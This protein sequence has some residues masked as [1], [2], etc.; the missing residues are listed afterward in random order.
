MCIPRV[1][2]NLPRSWSLGFGLGLAEHAGL[3]S[4]YWRFQTAFQYRSWKNTNWANKN[5]YET[6]ERFTLCGCIP[7]R[8]S[9]LAALHVSVWSIAA[10][11]DP[12][13]GK[14]AGEQLHCVLLFLVLDDAVERKRE[15]GD[16]L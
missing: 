15:A 11:L 10:R 16:S 1:P 3:S 7:L 4:L 14:R 5:G 2:A 13:L 12:R 6:L 9:A 8:L